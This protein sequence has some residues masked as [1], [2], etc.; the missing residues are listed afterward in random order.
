[1]FQPDLLA[2]FRESSMTDAAYVSNDL[3]E[4]SHMIKLLLCLQLQFTIIK[5]EVVVVYS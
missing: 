2:I 3:L 5:I 4:F 1:M